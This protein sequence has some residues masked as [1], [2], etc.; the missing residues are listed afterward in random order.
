MKKKTA[1]TI[2]NVVAVV[3]VLNLFLHSWVIVLGLAVVAG[4]LAWIGYVLQESNKNL[5]DRPLDQ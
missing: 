2:W 3:A 4:I 5:F 1:V